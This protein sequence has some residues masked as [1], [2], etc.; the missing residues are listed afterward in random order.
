MGAIAPRRLQRA[1]S[2]LE[3]SLLQPRPFLVAAIAPPQGA[4]AAGNLRRP[5]LAGAVVLDAQYGAVAT[6]LRRQRQA[7]PGVGGVTL[8]SDLELDDD[9]RAVV[10]LLD[11]LAVAMLGA[12][13]HAA[14]P[15]RR[16]GERLRRRACDCERKEE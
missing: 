14:G 10:V 7:F 6:Q 12:A 5:P 4:Q 2:L 8:G 3:E 11:D 9:A 1:G 15:F 13:D 16:L